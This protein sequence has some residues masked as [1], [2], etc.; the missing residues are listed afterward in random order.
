M[1]SEKYLYGPFQFFTPKEEPKDLS[2]A[3]VVM[4]R[5]TRDFTNAKY[6]INTCD[7]F[8]LDKFFEAGFDHPD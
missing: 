4:G 1:L 6:L 8:S 3:Y 2:E 7:T 5:S